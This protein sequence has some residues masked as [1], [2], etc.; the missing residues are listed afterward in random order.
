MRQTEG[1][2]NVTVI[3]GGDGAGRGGGG[4]R[5][6]FPFS[7]YAFSLSVLHPFNRSISVPRPASPACQPRR[8]RNLSPRR[9]RVTG[10]NQR[11]IGAGSP[12]TCKKRNTLSL[13]NGRTIRT[14]RAGETDLPFFL[15]PRAGPRGRR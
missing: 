6:M 4:Q 12:F 7:R 15:L 5:P 11:N 1:V 9:P 8:T 3:S 13:I 2:E 14:G 10:F